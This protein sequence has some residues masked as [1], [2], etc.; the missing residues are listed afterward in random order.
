MEKQGNA[1]HH[2]E[3]RKCNSVALND[4]FEGKNG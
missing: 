3:P 1:I 2:T 4:Y